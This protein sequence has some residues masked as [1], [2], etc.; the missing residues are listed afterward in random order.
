MDEKEKLN[1]LHAVVPNV[2]EVKEDPDNTLEAEIRRVKRENLKKLYKALPWAVGAG[3]TFLIAL[4]FLILP[5]SEMELGHTGF[6]A[7]FRAWARAFVYTASTAG[8]AIAT[9]IVSNLLNRLYAFIRSFAN[10]E[11]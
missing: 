11:K 1:Q 10:D 5:V 9:L 6:I 8:I 2:S 3:L 4:F 7:W